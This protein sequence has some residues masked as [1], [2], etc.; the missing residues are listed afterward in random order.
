MIKAVEELI[1]KYQ[2]IT[3][4]QLRSL[5]ETESEQNYGCV[6]NGGWVLSL[7]TNFGSCACILCKAAN[8]HCFNCIH[9]YNPD[10]DQCS[11]P[12][13]D[14]LYTNM[15]EARTPEELYGYIQNRIEYLNY[16]IERSKTNL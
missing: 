9:K 2:S 7:I 6:I 16:L 1:D 11:T 10:W 5:W 13:I 8:Q 12:C 15:E 3:L 4:D 14:G